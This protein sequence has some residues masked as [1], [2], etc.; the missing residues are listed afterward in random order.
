MSK[1]PLPMHI[2]FN[3]KSNGDGSMPFKIFTE[4]KIMSK[5]TACLL[6]PGTKV[7][8]LFL[9]FSFSLC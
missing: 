1:L 7:V 4:T 5:A 6:G 3:L 8:V 9:Q 2:F